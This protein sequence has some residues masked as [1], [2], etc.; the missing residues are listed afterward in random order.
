MATDAMG[1]VRGS[2]NWFEGE[3]IMLARVPTARVNTL[4]SRIGEALPLGASLVW[5]V[6]IVAAVCR[7][8]PGH[9]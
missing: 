6:G 7:R 9:G 1:R 2:A 5:L 8:V 4:Y 3:R